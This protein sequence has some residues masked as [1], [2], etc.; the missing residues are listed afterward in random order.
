MALT[1]T[2]KQARYRERHLGV[3]GEKARVGLIITMENN[4]ASLLSTVDNRN[5]RVQQ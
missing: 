1:T 2:E 4:A 5:K 3:G